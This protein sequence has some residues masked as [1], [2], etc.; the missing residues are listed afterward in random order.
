MG[1][2]QFVKNKMSLKKIYSIFYPNVLFGV[3]RNGKNLIISYKN[4]RVKHRI[5]SRYSR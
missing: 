2:T 4:V 3:T 5:Y 1:K